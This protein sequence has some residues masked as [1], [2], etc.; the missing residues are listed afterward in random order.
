MRRFGFAAGMAA[1][2]L[3]GLMPATVSA[4]PV[5]TFGNGYDG[6]MLRSNCISGQG[7]GDAPVHVVWKGPRGAVKAVVDVTSYAS[8][9]WGYCSAAKRLAVGDTIRAS[10]G[11]YARTFTMPNITLNGNRINGSFSGIGLP[12]ATGQLWYHAG[13]FADYFENEPVTADGQG[14]WSFPDGAHGG[15]EAYVEWMTPKGDFLMASMMV[16]YVEVT[17]GSA[18][19]EGGGRAY[20]DVTVNL[21]DASTNAL[22]GR[23]AAQVESW[24]RFGGSFR[25]SAGKLAKVKVGDRIVSNLAS[26]LDWH[27]PAISGSAD[28]A[29]DWVYG[30]CGSTEIAPIFAV[31]RV[32]RTGEER[33]LAHAGVDSNGDVAV[34]FGRR[35]DMFYDPANIKHGDR[36]VISCYY[37]TYDVVS[38]PFRVA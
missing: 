11:P 8:G 6:L 18:T 4:A 12:G 23:A 9:A 7:P 25:N 21:R 32:Y 20:A 14:R 35:P 38:F 27:V 29:N 31:V 36:V 22:L 5:M 19:V 17:I 33:G 26:N 1:L 24:G 2:L 15:I 37:D 34:D 28:V 13:I 3:V 16:P 10:S 30:N